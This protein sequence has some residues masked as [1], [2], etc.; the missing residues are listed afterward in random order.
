MQKR[1]ITALYIALCLLAVLILATAPAWGQAV[2]AS[3]TGAVIDPS[4]APVA[5]AAVIARDVNR[6]T[7]FPTQTNGDGQYNL[8]Q[9][10]IGTYSVEATASG[11][12]RALKPAF[13][14]VLNQ[15][16]KIDFQMKVGQVSETIE[17]TAQTPLLQ[18]ETTQLNTVMEANAIAEP[19][20]RNPQLQPAHAAA[21]R[22][23]SPPARRRS[24]PARRP[25]TPAALISTATASRPTTTCWTAWRTSEFVDNNVAYS[26][27]VD[28]IQEFNVITN[29]PP[30]RIM[31]S[32]WAA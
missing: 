21:R 13:D 14:L 16:A 11:F 26:P 7:E 28:A 32:F 1:Q 24:I 22:A 27:N 30:A 15:V 6:G 12:D 2:T 29:N 18:T 20:A 5:G 25:S 31:A 19:A 17:V 10:P 9:L 8:P 4:G 3:I 23:P